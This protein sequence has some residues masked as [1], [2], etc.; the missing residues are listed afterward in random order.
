MNKFKVLIADSSP[1]VRHFIKYSLQDHFPHVEFEVATNGKNIKKRIENTHYDI[2][3]Y[4]REMPMLQGDELLEWLRHHETIK[5]IA[6]IMISGNTDEGSLKRAIALGADAY[7]IKPL[8]MDPLV[9]KVREIFTR[10]ERDKFD[11]RRHE[12]IKCQGRVSFKFSSGQNS[13]KLINISMGGVLGLFDR[14]FPLPH[15]L[16]KVEVSVGTE[17]NK[18]I[19][20][21]EGE[22]IRIQVIDT[23]AGPQHIQFAVKFINEISAEKKSKLAELVASFKP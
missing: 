2:I 12:R 7:L 17:G 21:M 18:S 20:N 15:I 1:S 3:L 10:F 19:I 5:N 23:F 9:S 16:E 13:G 6:F 11:R 8:L 4:D 22:I 14:E